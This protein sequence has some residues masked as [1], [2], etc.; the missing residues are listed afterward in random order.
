MTPIHDEE[1]NLIVN[2]EL[3]ARKYFKKWFW[4]DLVTCF[5][6]ML[7]ADESDLTWFRRII[8]MSL[9]TKLLKPLKYELQWQDAVHKQFLTSRMVRGARVTIYLMIALHWGTCAWVAMG[10]EE[11][12]DQVRQRA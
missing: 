5:P 1:M 10:W 12:N 8:S 11:W 7:F 2:R 6:F 9:F 3:I 4:I